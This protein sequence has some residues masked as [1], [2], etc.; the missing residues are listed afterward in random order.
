MQADTVAE[1][2]RHSLL[3][4]LT[5]WTSALSFLVLVLSGIAILLA[6]PRLYWGESGSLETSSLIDLPLPFVLHVPIRGPGRYLHFLFAWVAVFTGLVYLS[7]G[8]ARRHFGRNLLPA[9]DQLTLGAIRRVIGKHLRFERS[10]EAELASYN[11]LQRLSYTTVVFVLFPLIICT[12]LAMSPAVVSVVP[13]VV[14]ALGGQQ[15]ART[16]HF[17]VACSLVLFVLVH[18]ALVWQTGF[19][20][21][22]RAMITGRASSPAPAIVTAGLSRRQ[23]IKTGLGALAG[24]GAFGVGFRV[25][26][27]CG[28]VPAN[29]RGI[30]GLSETLTYAGQR[31]LTKL[32]SMAR[33]FGRGQITKVPPVNGKAPKTEP[34]QGL[35]AGGFADWRLQVEGLVARP[36]ALSLAEIKAL[37]SRSHITHQAC[38]EGWSFIAEWTGAPLAHVLE[39]VGIRPEA[40]YVFFFTFDGWWDSL[41]MDD[42]LHPQTL[43]AYAMNGPELPLDHGA[44]LRLKVTRQL[45]YKSLKYLTRMLVTDSA[46]G[47]GDGLGSSA[48]AAGYSWYAGI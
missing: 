29:R 45:G 20:R 43:L 32:P 24:A 34:Y 25:A 46:Q 31:L 26:D 21:R 35:L 6:H 44:P 1:G 5:H 47:V 19:R 39:H 37:P 13:L 10:S 15:T 9:R 14:T 18:V 11:V 30:Y 12:G 4:R 16:I 48:P 41:D 2:P 3:V 8:L 23:L 28:L 42:A 36:G 38:E 40:R 27:R 17:F 7:M 33:E 22:M